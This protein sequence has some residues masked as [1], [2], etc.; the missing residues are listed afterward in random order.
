MIRRAEETKIKNWCF[1]LFMTTLLLIGGS[2]I[3][4]VTVLHAET[5]VTYK[6]VITVDLNFVEDTITVE[7]SDSMEPFQKS[8]VIYYCFTVN[9][10]G[11][12]TKPKEKDWVA[13]VVDKVESD[14][15]VKIDI[16]WVKI[17]K[18]STLFVCTDTDEEKEIQVDFEV[19]PPR[20]TLK[21][22]AAGEIPKKDVS[23]YIG[24]NETGYLYVKS[25]KSEDDIGF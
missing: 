18:V 20:N 1:V 24:N 2:I 7:K 25:T 19:Y 11:E 6:P 21:I 17:S 14:K 4:H 13:K 23:D 10:K 3:R 12:Q 5:A 22:V 9:K 15:S 16:S 8:D